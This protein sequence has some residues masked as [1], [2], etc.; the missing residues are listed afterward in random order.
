[1]LGETRT[2]VRRWEPPGRGPFDRAPRDPAALSA[3]TPALRP[4]LLSSR[5]SLTR[6]VTQLLSQFHRWLSARQD[7]AIARCA[8]LRLTPCPARAPQATPWR[9]R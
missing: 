1:M 9:K 4:R 8:E 2:G 5:I 7:A 6:F 3:L